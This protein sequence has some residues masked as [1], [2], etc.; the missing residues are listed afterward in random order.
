[1][2]AALASLGISIPGLI[3][4]LITFVVLWFLL[5][6]ALFKPVLRMFDR[7][8]QAI[9]EAARKAN[10]VKEQSQAGEEQVRKKLDDA[11]VQ[12]QAII[13]QA[14]R[15]AGQTRDREV[16]AARKN[17]EQSLAQA[18]A[19]IQAQRQ[20]AIAELRSLFPD[21]VYA[22][23]EKVL[24]GPANKQAGQKVIEDALAKVGR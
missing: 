18:K 15:Q 13:D 23:A 1:M 4:S 20:Q 22:A 11:R 14:L 6:Q 21:L 17:A 12:A 3:V 10:E 2:G 5:S 24:N 7:R 8:E 9:H 16:A 19:D